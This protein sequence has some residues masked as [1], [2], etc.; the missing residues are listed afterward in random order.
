MMS[1]L[2]RAWCTSVLLATLELAVAAYPCTAETYPS[3]PISIIVPYV[4]GGSTDIIIRMFAD[5]LRE[6]LGQPV[7]IV[8][9]PGAQGAIGFEAARRAAPD[10][11]TLVGTA[12]ALP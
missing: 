11:Y 7:V 3:R 4:A 2:R 12:N 10:G 1:L 5:K 8:N 9:R 6:Q